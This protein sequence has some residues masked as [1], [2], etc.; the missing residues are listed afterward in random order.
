MRVKPG[1]KGFFVHPIIY[2]FTK[3]VVKAGKKN[4]ILSFVSN[5]PTLNIRSSF[6]L[7][8]IKKVSIQVHDGRRLIASHPYDFRKTNYTF[9]IGQTTYNR[10]L[11]EKRSSKRNFQLVFN[12]IKKKKGQ[13]LKISRRKKY[14]YFDYGASS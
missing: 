8:K 6:Y 4:P 5:I 11:P 9:K 10:H 1:K 7:N 2:N 12:D 13:V 3:K 14:V